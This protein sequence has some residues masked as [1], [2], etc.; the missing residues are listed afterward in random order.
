MSTLDFGPIRIIV[1]SVTLTVV[2]AGHCTQG[3]EGEGKVTA[4]G[5]ATIPAGMRVW[6]R[7]EGAQEMLRCG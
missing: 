6:E 1:F 4:L 3:E 5:A 2:A 7:E